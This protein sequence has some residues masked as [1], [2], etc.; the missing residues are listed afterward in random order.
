MS[1]NDN[2][3]YHNSFNNNHKRYDDRNEHYQNQEHSNVN[4]NYQQE[5]NSHSDNT[6]NENE[7]HSETVPATDN[8]KFKNYIQNVTRDN[9]ETEHL[10]RLLLIKSY[11][12]KLIQT[13]NDTPMSFGSKNLEVFQPKTRPLLEL[14][15]IELNLNS[16]NQLSK[17]LTTNISTIHRLYR[18]ITDDDKIIELDDG[19]IQYKDAERIQ[20]RKLKP[21]LDEV[22]EIINCYDEVLKDF[23]DDFK[24][25][26]DN[27]KLLKSN[28]GVDNDRSY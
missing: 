5:S 3:N 15:L 27:I 7:Q 22:G 14:L 4:N 23:D 19:T 17:I 6:H 2:Q 13:F 28:R 11:H 9:I 1:Y 26:K 24:F 20:A 12:S 25:S 10:V 16:L 18:P 8:N 21:F